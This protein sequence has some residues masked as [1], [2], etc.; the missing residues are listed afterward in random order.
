[1]N[2]SP[3]VTAALESKLNS[4]QAPQFWFFPQRLSSKFRHAHYSSARAT[5]SRKLFS[6]RQPFSHLVVKNSSSSSRARRRVCSNLKSRPW[7]RGRHDKVL[8]AALEIDVC[9]EGFTQWNTFSRVVVTSR[10]H[11]IVAGSPTVLLVVP[12]RPLLA[13]TCLH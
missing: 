4:E 12:N 1:L 11:G 7:L 10:A 13:A 2:R 9:A 8:I 6:K 5:I 3:R